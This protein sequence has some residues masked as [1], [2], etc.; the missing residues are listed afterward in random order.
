MEVAVSDQGNAVNRKLDDVGREELKRGVDKLA[1]AVRKT[2]TSEKKNSCSLCVVP[3]AYVGPIA[4]FFGILGILTFGLFGLTLFV[5]TPINERTLAD[6]LFILFFVVIGLILFGFFAYRNIFGKT[7]WYFRDTEGNFHIHRNKP[8]VS[9]DEFV[10]IDRERG[11]RRVATDGKPLLQRRLGGWFRKNVIHWGPN[12]VSSR[13]AITHAW[14][15]E[16]V[17]VSNPTSGISFRIKDIEILFNLVHDFP[18]GIRELFDVTKERCYAIGQWGETCAL[19]RVKEITE[20]DALIDYFV[21]TIV[22]AI[23]KIMRSRQGMGDSK[24]AKQIRQYLEACLEDARKIRS[25][26]P[27]AVRLEE[28]FSLWDKFEQDRKLTLKN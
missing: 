3:N 8:E 17:T 28:F 1:E 19:V 11:H 2:L 13:W 24:H 14:G 7:L 22:V 23:S 15:F 20:R 9:G 18:M 27:D 26:A 5:E 6:I 21:S 16:P 10:V 25:F 12:D 4:P